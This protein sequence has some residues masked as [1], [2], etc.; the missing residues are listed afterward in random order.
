MYET[1]TRQSLWPSVVRDITAFAGGTIGALQIRRLGP[2]PTTAMISS[3]LEPAFHQAYV[4]HHYLHDP[5]LQRAA[6]LTEGQTLLSRD[7]L[8]DE[9][10]QRTPYYNDYCRP[11]GIRDLMGVMLLRDAELAVSYATYAPDSRS[12]DERNRASLQRLVPHLS[13]VVRLTL[14]RERV[15]C[16]KAALEAGQ[17]ACETAIIVVDRTLR[18]HSMSGAIEHWL[19]QPAAFLAVQSGVLVARGTVQARLL[20]AIQRGLEGEAHKLTFDSLAVCIAPVASKSPFV[21]CGLVNVILVPVVGAS[22]EASMPQLGDLPPSLR[23][24]ACLMVRGAADKEIAIELG[25]TL[26]SARTYAARVLKRMGVQSRRELMRS[27]G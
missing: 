9:D 18:V 6:S 2:K 20:E 13:R 23:R 3:G 17:G 26:H 7:V 11:Q 14:E 12:F 8:S 22:S 10:F 4:E 5:H 21:P 1:L 24:V 15:G 16:L 19:G 25:M 27:R